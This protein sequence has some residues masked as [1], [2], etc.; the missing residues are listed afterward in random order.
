MRESRK[1]LNS[2]KRVGRL[3]KYVLVWSKRDSSCDARSM[4]GGYFLV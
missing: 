2:Y 4:F 3:V 1:L